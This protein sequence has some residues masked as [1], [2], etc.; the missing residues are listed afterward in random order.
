MATN[1]SFGYLPLGSIIYYASDQFIPDTFLLCDGADYS[2]ET[3]SL[4]FSV[5]GTNYGSASA[6]TFKVPDLVTYSYL[7]G[8]AV[9]NGV[10]SPAVVTAPNALLSSAT[11]PNLSQANF[12]FGSWNLTANINNGVWFEN[13]GSPRVEV[14]PL[15]SD[16]TVKANSTDISSYSAVKNAG[17]IGFSNGAQAPIVFTPDPTSEV[18]LDAVTLVPLVKAWYDFYPPDWTPLPVS[19]DSGYRQ[20]VPASNASFTTNPTG[21][22]LDDPQLSGFVFD[23]PTF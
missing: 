23:K 8:G 22:Y 17:T 11:I 9:S 10:P 14:V 7:K 12:A 13:S 6:T 4:L 18:E 1:S 16:S 21:I 15:G 20:P 3:Y 2:K 5:L 19:T